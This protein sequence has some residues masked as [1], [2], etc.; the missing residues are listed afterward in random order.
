MPKSYSEIAARIRVPMGLVLAFVYF[1]FAQPTPQRLL[2]GAAVALCGLM[3]RAAGAGHLA[4]NQVLATGGPYAYT[5]HPLYLGSTLAGI[6]YCIAG[7]QWWFFLVLGAF[8]GAVYWPVIRRE[9]IHL[10]QL[11]PD[12]FGV[13]YRAVPFLSLR[14]CDIALKQ[15]GPTR[16]SWELYLK[17][18]EYEAFVAYLAIVL[19]LVAKMLLFMHS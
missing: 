15:S 11:F 8:L 17:N 4:K 10:S 2:L 16:F 9:E 19:V 6:G 3:L 1:V 12:E 14:R 13:Y 18:R 5:R 7:G